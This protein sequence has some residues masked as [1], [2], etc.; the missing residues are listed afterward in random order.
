MGRLKN[1]T[2]VLLVRG[3]K[4]TSD[5]PTP[6]MRVPFHAIRLDVN[7]SRALA[8]VADVL[9]EPALRI[10]PLRDAIDVPYAYDIVLT[11]GFAATVVGF[12]VL[13]AILRRLKAAGY[14]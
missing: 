11:D 8:H 7:P 13:R 14:L 9:H 3:T 6:S 2:C 4:F 12:V 1:I 10:A 5:K